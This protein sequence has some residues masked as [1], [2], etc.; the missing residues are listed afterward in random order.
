VAQVI[1]SLSES[2]QHSF[3]NVKY[4]MPQCYSYSIHFSGPLMNLSSG[5]VFTF[6]LYLLY[7]AVNCSINESKIPCVYQEKLESLRN[8]HYKALNELCAR[9][10]VL[11]VSYLGVLNLYPNSWLWVTFTSYFSQFLHANPTSMFFLSFNNSPFQTIQPHYKL[12]N[13]PTEQYNYLNFIIL[14]HIGQDPKLL[15]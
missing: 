2:L 7:P 15:V 4:F 10:T 13:E 8:R 5:L 6:Y 11:L 14:I 1:Y 12:F 9:I 3:A